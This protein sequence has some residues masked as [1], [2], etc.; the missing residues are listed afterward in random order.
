MKIN[1]IRI[2]EEHPM[3]VGDISYAL[4]SIDLH[5]DS[6]AG[7]NGY[8]VKASDGLGPTDLTA[9]VEGF[10]SNGI[11]IMG[12][13]SS[14]RDMA[15]KMGLIPHG[16]ND[17]SN[18]RDRVYRY[19][20]RSV[21]VSLMYGSEVV[22]KTKG[23]IRQP[24]ASYFTNQPELIITIECVDGELVA[25]KAV[26]IPFPRLSVPQPVITYE[27]GTAPTGLDLVFTVTENHSNFTISN[28]AKV[29]HKGNGNIQT[30]FS[31][32]YDF[33]VGDVISI[34]T[35][36]GERRISLLR[37]ST[38]YDLAGYLNSGA[39]WPRLYPGVNVFDWD[40]EVDWMAWTSASY[41][42]RF[43]GV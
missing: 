16:Q 28:H 43:W 2:E 34:S 32:T 19:M 18:L 1:K 40:I 8:L 15:F 13:K 24:D 33:L 6:S 27:A 4:P 14:R 37:S 12:T 20:S 22:A 5:L 9:V 17:F 41:L 29:W 30:E 39:V 10:D 23:H 38:A 25:P 21:V 26:N 7:E 31:V 3:V 35:Y 42:P 36:Q 11:P